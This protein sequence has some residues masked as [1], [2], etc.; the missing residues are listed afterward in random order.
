[1]L[2]GQ[3]ETT[4]SALKAEW[5]DLSPDR[6]ALIGVSGGRDSV[7]LLHCLAAL[8]WRKLVVCH[9]DHRL[10]GAE[11]TADATFV[12]KLAAKL[13]L[14]YVEEKKDIAAIAEME[15][16][17]TELTGRR[18]RYDFFARAARKHRTHFVFLAHHADDNAE[19]IVGNLFRGTGL[20]GLSGM[21]SSSLSDDGLI[22]L[23]PLLGVR[24][25]DIDEFVKSS[26][27]SYRDDSTNST[28]DHRRN[29]IRNEVLP[30]LCDVFGR[31]V[32]PI[33]ERVA[34]TARR[35][36]ACLESLARQFAHTDS[37][38]QSDGS[39]RI[40]PELQ[41]ADP[42]IQSRIL[43]GL[44]LDVA[45]CSGI[46]SRE[47]E[48]AMSMLSTGGPAKINLPGNRHLRRKAKRLWVE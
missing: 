42:A 41:T 33:I 20:A 13:D 29:R 23:R 10:R 1:M 44:L 25:S 43:F 11:S 3:C 24:R 17:S 2:R 8:G 28:G 45:G 4:L 12:R 19:T 15:S 38:F 21:T 40:T 37:L 36:H 22:K 46:T 14:R 30:L 39:L 9:L 27:I 26:A 16:N 47:I 32:T 18:A 34:Q 31:D 5:P 6:A 7:A 35:D 48:A